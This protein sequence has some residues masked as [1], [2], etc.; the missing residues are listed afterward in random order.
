MTGAAQAPIPQQ[1]FTPMCIVPVPLKIASASAVLLG[2]YGAVTE[3]AHDRGVHRQTIYRET[4]AVVEAVDGSAHRAQLEEL[5]QRLADQQRRLDE[6][7]DRLRDAV[8]LDADKQAKFAAVG[9]A[10]GVSLPIARR[11][12]EVF[13]DRR[14]PSVAKLGRITQAAGRR[15]G[16]AL[17][18]LDEPSRAR[19]RQVAPDEIFVG[20]R[21]ILMTVEQ[22]SLCWLG[23]R[24]A[25]RRDGEQW[26]IEFR[27]L[28]ALEQVTRDAGTGLEKGLERL[29]CERREK[30]LEPVADQLD[31]FHL[32]REGTR[33]L[34]R[35]QG[36]ASRALA[37]ADKAQKELDR[38][39]RRGQ[40]R[41]GRTT[42]VRGLWRQAEAAMDRWAAGERAWQRLHSGLGLFTPEG[43]LNTRPQAETV[44]A[45]VLPQLEGSEWAKAKR[46]LARPELFTFLDR[47]Q[48]QLAALPVEPGTRDAV[49]RAEGLRR[50]PELVQ[51]E[52]PQAV[53]L[54]GVLLAAGVLLVVGGEAARQ[55]AGAVREVLRQA[56]RASS[57]VEGLNS[58]LRMQQAR[59]RR[60]TQGLLDLKRLYWNCRRFRTGR[61][62][63]QTP[64]GRLGIR[65]PGSG[66][67]ELL[68]VPPEQLRQQLSAQKDAA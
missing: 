25:Q 6:L 38:H 31:H 56:W 22:D 3:H 10:E 44:V 48:V 20:R 1:E 33:A 14:T 18:V 41:A 32:L 42:I 17:A 58:V 26:A 57:L 16:A 50:H 2:P 28:P 47:V 52:G 19:A 4:A 5:H 24:L 66:W 67:W 15:S 61:R 29:N 27:Q 12:L 37:Q 30:G 55:A 11:L 34:R 62:K 49:V 21:P 60:L 64:Y 13:L 53:A 54:R 40:N 59:H 8:V 9:E 7:E 35:L 45:E 65:L 36:Q 51:G 68:K 39:A 43:E 46:L 63:G 23:G